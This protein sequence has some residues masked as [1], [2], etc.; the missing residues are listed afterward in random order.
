LVASVY[1][2]NFQHIPEL[3]WT[4]GYW[5]ALGLMALIGASL[6]VVFRRIDWI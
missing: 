6:V 2:M 3:G 4:F 1:G 5:W